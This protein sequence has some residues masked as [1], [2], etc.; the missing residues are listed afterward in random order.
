MKILCAMA[1]LSGVAYLLGS[2]NCAVLI[3]RLF[4]GDDV[5]NHGSGNAGTTNMMRTFGYKAGFATFLGDVLK[6]T[7]SVLIARWLAPV[8]GLEAVHAAPAAAIAA[9]L[10]HMYPVYFRFQGGKGVATAFGAVAALHPLILLVLIA[11]GLPLIL[12]TGYVSLGSMTG[13]ALY[14]FILLGTMLY[15]GRIDEL[16]LLLAILLVGIILGNHRENLRRLREGTENKFY[17]KK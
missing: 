13:A 16:S 10:G 12:I 8:F 1:G 9:M 2:I 5:R 14:P 15:R 6:G 17:K 11:V 3:S 4:F 7:L